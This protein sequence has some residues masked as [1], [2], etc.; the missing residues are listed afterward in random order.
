M[1][2][3]KAHEQYVKELAEVNPAL[4]VIGEYKHS[5]IPIRIRCKKCGHDWEVL[6]YNLLRG[7]GCPKCALAKR[8]KSRKQFIREVMKINPNIKII[9]PYKNTDTPIECEC[10]IC[11]YHWRP[12]PSV[13]I[14]GSGCPR[15][16]G[17]AP[18]KT[19]C[20]ENVP[21]K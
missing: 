6:P 19:V 3:K 18:K 7:T 11:G 13:L 10:L 2:K 20:T 17:N 8:R 9:G 4:E 14:R 16:A 12:R 21:K 15:C 5:H 1:A